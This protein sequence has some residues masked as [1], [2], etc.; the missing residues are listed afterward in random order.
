[1]SRL[2]TPVW[3]AIKAQFLNKS[4]D[5]IRVEVKKEYIRTVTRMIQKEKWQ[6][7]FW[8]LSSLTKL[9]HTIEEQDSGY[10]VIT[11]ELRPHNK[12]FIFKELLSMKNPNFEP[13]KLL[14]TTEFKMDL[15]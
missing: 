1:M 10:V 13:N 7:N 6:D 2:Y 12:S 5:K 9:T 3:E 11:F 15:D 8:G 14:N 4:E